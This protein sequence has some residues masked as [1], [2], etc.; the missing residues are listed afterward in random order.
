MHCWLC[1]CSENLLHLFIAL[2]LV[3]RCINQSLL[4]YQNHFIFSLL[5][6]V[7]RHAILIFRVRTDM[8]IFTASFIRKSYTMVKLSKSPRWEGVVQRLL[9]VSTW[10]TYEI[11][12][13]ISL[14][15]IHNV[16]LLRGLGCWCGWARCV[17]LC[18]TWS[19]WLYGAAWSF[20]WTMKSDPLLLITNYTQGKTC[21]SNK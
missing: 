3:S 21:A 6:I 10:D 11:T 9:V 2:S 4:S 14:G 1:T 18:V 17:V 12:Y 5:S 7:S 8:S 20:F 19:Q 16:L 13:A 15:V